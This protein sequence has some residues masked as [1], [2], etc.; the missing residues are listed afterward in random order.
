MLGD[1]AAVDDPAP[2]VVELEEVP[3]EPEHGGDVAAG[4]HLEVDVGDPG[5]AAGQHLQGVLRIDEVDEAASRAG[6]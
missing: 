5:L 4:L 2:G 1:E 6:D 3:G